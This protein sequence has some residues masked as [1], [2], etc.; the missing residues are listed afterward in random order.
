MTVSA[1]H[2]QPVWPKSPPNQ[3][4]WE[5]FRLRMYADPKGFAVV[6]RIVVAHLQLWNRESLLEAAVCCVSELLA[7][8]HRHVG[9]PGPRCELVLTNLPDGLH[10]SMSDESVEVPVVRDPEWSQECGR[11]I[12]LIS[13]YATTFG[14][15]QSAEG[16][17][18]WVRLREA[19][20]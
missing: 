8:V 13:H 7:N 9:V 3:G 2:G 6:R 16:K 14:H 20:A 17:T 11:G 19:A 15:D 1:A 18:I 4:D 12:V 5:S 10:F